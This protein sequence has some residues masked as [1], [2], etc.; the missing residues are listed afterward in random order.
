MSVKWDGY[1]IYD[2]GPYGPLDALPRPEARQAFN[3]IM[4]AKPRRIEMLVNLLKANGIVLNDDKSSIQDLNDWYRRN[5]AEDPSAPGRLIPDWYSVA[6]DIGLFLGD[7]FIARH[8]VLRWEFFTWGKKNVSYQRHVIMGFG[9]P[10]WR[11]NLDICRQVGV[12][13][14]RIISGHEEREDNFCHWFTIVDRRV[15]EG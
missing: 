15:V 5:V 2:P 7:L 1:G 8:P 14:H 6:S 9:K 13:G 4:E 11:T 10:E 12:Y 3:K